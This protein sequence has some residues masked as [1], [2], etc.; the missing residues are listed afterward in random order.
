MYKE[1]VF[2]KI[3]L[4]CNL[5]NASFFDTCSRNEI[6][7]SECSSCQNASGNVHHGLVTYRVVGC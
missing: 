5:P 1:V 3:R 4:D 2:T 6:L 7:K